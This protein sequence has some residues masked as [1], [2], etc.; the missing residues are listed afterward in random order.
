LQGTITAAAG[1]ASVSGVTVA[2]GARSA[3]TDGSGVYSFASIPAGT[4]P[5]VTVSK[6][7]LVS[8]TAAPIV[9]TDGGSTTKDFA[10][11]AA[12]SSGCLTDTTQSDFQTG[13]PAAVDLIT[14]PGNVTLGTALT[15]NLVSGLKDSNPA[16]ALM[17]AWSTLS[18]TSTTPANTSVKFQVAGSNSD[19]GPFN[20]VGPDG[21]NATFFTAAGSSLSQ[22][23]GLRY[24]EY[25]AYLATTTNTVKPTLSDVT[26]C[27]TNADCSG[28]TATITAPSPICSN[29]TG[30]TASGPAGKAS[31]LWSITTPNGTVTSGG[32]S[33]TVT[34]S[35]GTGPA[36]NLSLTTVDGAG[37]QAS[38]AKSVLIITGPTVTPASISN[39][40]VGAAMSVTFGAS[41][42]A[43]PSTLS[44]T[45]TLPPNL[46]FSGGTLSGTPNTIGTYT[47][48]VT[49]TDTNG[50]S[51][52]RTY[53]FA[54]ASAPGTA[55]ANVTATA[56]NTTQVILSW[57]PVGSATSYD[58]IRKAPGGAPIA[59]GSITTTVYGDAQS[60]VP[61]STYIYTVRANGP[62][63]PAN[64]ISLPDIATMVVFTDD[65]LI[66]GST[67]FKGVHLTELRSAVNAVR[68][69]A[70]LTAATFTDP[71]PAGKTAKALYIQELRAALDPARSAIGV[72]AMA[73]SNPASAGTIVRAIDL[74][75]I[76]N[77]VK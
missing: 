14:S 30:N 22:F 76:R 26:L 36:V 46:Q 7:G 25:K 62:G 10:L 72:P 19:S 35:V 50:C 2:F 38:A 40:T 29:S 68:A 74:A 34:Y 63:F 43:P 33:Q 37:C 41:G 67:P 32:T 48:T 31:Y 27:Y 28:A 24:L 23:A 77:G 15:G 13:V 44:L 52:S 66:A 49:A 4:Y 70:G 16:A 1:G 69:A 75:Q 8:Q 59:L 56:I 3:T 42:G 6:P 5:A 47:I 61:G 60:L 54:I 21:T 65:P 17:P 39:G 51:G 71:A 45:G 20:F 9:I 12:A 73:Y 53:T 58:V 57:N 64:A 11:S 18:W 55:P